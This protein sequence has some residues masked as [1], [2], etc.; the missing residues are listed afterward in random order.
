MLAGQSGPLGILGMSEM[1]S[2]RHGVRCFSALRGSY[3]FV[4]TACARGRFPLL[5]RYVVLIFGI[6]GVLH[7]G[8]SMSYTVVSNAV[9]PFRD[10]LLSLPALVVA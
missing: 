10:D 7:L 9:V 5:G 2:G 4:Q 1:R 3:I 6:P 8:S